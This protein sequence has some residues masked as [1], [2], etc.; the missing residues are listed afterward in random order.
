MPSPPT[1]S[2]P[3]LRE[4]QTVSEARILEALDNLFA[5]YYPVHHGARGARAAP[6]P[7]SP[8]LCEAAV[9]AAKPFGHLS[10]RFADVTDSGYN[11]GYNSDDEEG[12]EGVEGDEDAGG[13]AAERLRADEHERA[14]AVRWV[15][16]FIA[17]GEEVPFESEEG[18]QGVLDQ[19]AE[20]LNVLLNPHETGEEEGRGD[21]GNDDNDHWFTRD[22]T[23]ALSGKDDGRYRD[24]TPICVRVNDGLAGQKGADHTDVGLQTW[25]AA[26]VLCQMMCD[27]AARFGLTR[28]ALGEEPRVV[29]LGAGTGLVSLL[30]G[31]LLPRVGVERATIVATDYHPTVCENLRQNVVLNYGECPEGRTVLARKLDWADEKLSKDWPLA[32]DGKADL[33]IATDVVYAAEHARMLYGCA[34]RLLTAEG[35]FWLVATVRQ[36]GRFNGVDKTVEDVFCD[37][38]RP[39]EPATGKRLTILESQNLDKRNGVG[40]GDETF[41]KMFRVG[42]A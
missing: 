16:R 18:R 33:L 24:Y 36:N 23:F 26:V 27:D 42:W 3:P 12:E 13:L 1:S 41:Y 6:A 20:L 30:L 15:T 25:G 5:I 17:V 4:P 9:A 14:F 29:E 32:G 8:V 31:M 2:L 10:K 35:T 37:E 22:F 28:A 39:R 40:R 21:D 7:P 19:A 11:S 34:S 38:A